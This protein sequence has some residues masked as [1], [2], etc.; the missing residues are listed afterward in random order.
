[1]LLRLRLP[2]GNKLT[3]KEIDYYTT[4][5][6][7]YGAKGLAYI[8][9]NDVALGREGLQSPILKFLPDDVLTSIL[10]RT[11]AATSDLIFFGADKTRVVNDSL[12]ALQVKLGEDLNLL[13]GQ[14]SPVWV[15]DFPMFHYNDDEQRWDSLH[16]PFTAPQVNTARGTTRGSG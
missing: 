2:A 10:E 9:V 5:V 14:W 7:N 1:M 16:H 3:R 12:A 6:S 15:I 8:K 11:G 13:E 4:Y